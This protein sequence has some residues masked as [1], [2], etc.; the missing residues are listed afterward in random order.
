MN[1][2]VLCE[3]REASAN[4][5]IAI[6]IIDEL[7]KRK[8]NVIDGYFVNGQIGDNLKSFTIQSAKSR[9]YLANRYDEAW[10]GKNKYEKFKFL[11]KNLRFLKS[12]INFKLDVKSGY[13]DCRKRIKKLS[14]KGNIDYIIGISYPHDI[15]RLLSRINISIPVAVFRL[16]P[17][18]FNPCFPIAEFEQRLEEER[19]WIPKV[20]K[21]FTTNLIINDLLKDKIIGQYSEKLCPIEF[22]LISETDPIVIRNKNH[23]FLKKDGEVYLL[24]AGTF[25]E[26]IRNPGKLVHFVKKLPDNYILLV[27]GTN[28]ETI[29]N[30]DAEIHNRVVDLGCLS[31]AEINSVIEDS[32]FLISYNNLNTNMIPSKIFEYIDSGKPFIN[33][34]HNSLCPTIDYVKGYEMAYT[35]ILDEFTDTNNLLEFMKRTKGLKSSRAQI[36][37]KFKK[38][39]IPYV[40]NQLLECCFD[41]GGSC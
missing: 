17:Y 35:V 19:K 25:Y 7:K 29:I 36:L 38:N 18:A 32:D 22:P 10:C 6:K 4:Y 21:L 20:T 1:I 13:K 12:Y 16:D 15:E 27:A 31:R 40:V 9:Y 28:T 23:L 2:L 37:S 34:C 33:L 30:Y 41:K 14:S 11:L 39:T 5:N 8:I 3:Y 24:H 26:D